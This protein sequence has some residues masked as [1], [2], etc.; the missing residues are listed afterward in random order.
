MLYQLPN[1]KVIHLSVEEYLSL[2]DQD[3]QD[4]SAS[5]LGDYATSPWTDSAIRKPRKNQEHKDVDKR[6]D[7]QEES[8][9]IVI[10]S[11][12]LTT[13]TIDEINSSE[14]TEEDNSQELEDT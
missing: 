13:F 12:S 5:N 11:V 7:Y 14:I 9:E 3:I 6:I 10:Q 8:D 2:S 1:G 4:L